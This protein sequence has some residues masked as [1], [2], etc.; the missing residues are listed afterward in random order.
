MP[1]GKIAVAALLLSVCMA[2]LGGHPKP[3][4]S[5]AGLDLTASFSAERR[6]ISILKDVTASSDTTGVERSLAVTE[7]AIVGRFSFEEMMTRLACL[8]QLGCRPADAQRSALQLFRQWWETQNSSGHGPGPFCDGRLFGFA[9]ACDRAEGLELVRDGGN[10]FVDPANHAGYLTIGLFNRIDLADASGRDCGEYRIV[11]ARRSGLSAA[12]RRLLINFEAVLPNPSPGRG[13]AGCRPVAKFWKSLETIDSATERA[14]RLWDFYFL[15][16]PGFSPVVHPDHYG[17]RHCGPDHPH[18]TGQIRTNQ[19]MQGPWMLREFQLQRAC[20][21]CR[22]RFVPRRV[23][24]SPFGELFGDRTDIL[25]LRFQD[26]FIASLPSLLWNQDPNLFSYAVPA[27]FT[28]SQSESCRPTA[29]CDKQPVEGNYLRYLE[30]GTRLQRRIFES[31]K[32]AGL[33]AAFTPKQVVRRAQALSC[34]GCHELSRAQELGT[35]THQPNPWPESLGFVHVSERGAF[36]DSYPISDALK[37]SFLPHRKT[38]LTAILNL[39]P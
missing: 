11:F 27:E 9:F 37:L 28:S 36:G 35:P 16:L 31:L 18:C 3:E 38:K 25:A 34:A 6:G 26:L 29:D 7:K 23:A 14:Q 39:S 20:P 17:A 2:S 15:G 5:P 1:F 24:Q 19:F 13:L 33:E 8:P 30:N 10:P 12:D 4:A 21:T 32:T 22:L